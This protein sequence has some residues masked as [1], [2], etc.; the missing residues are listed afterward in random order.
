MDA[1]ALARARKAAG[2][3]DWRLA[4]RCFRAADA[5]VPLGAED[6]ELL[7]WACAWTGDLDL[8]IA[9]WERAY[10]DWLAEGRPDRAAV[11]AFWIAWW[12]VDKGHRSVAAGWY[13]R[14]ERLSAG[15]DAASRPQGYAELVRAWGARHRA[16]LDEAVERGGRAREL[17]TRAGDRDL[18]AFSMTHLAR[19]AVLAGD[20]EEGLRLADEAGAAAVGHELSPGA[21]FVVYCNVVALHFG[22]ADLKRAAEW[23][24][25][26]ARWC[27][28]QSLVGFPG[29]CRVEH[30]KVLSLTG[31]WAAAIA[32]A[33]RACAELEPFAPGLAGDAF[34]QLGELRLRT[35]DL[36]GAEAYFARAHELG[37]VP[38]P[39]RSLLLAAADVGAGLASI[40]TALQDGSWYPLERARL[41]PTFAELALA[42]GEVGAAAEAADELARIAAMYGSSALEATAATARGRVQL[43]RGE[44]ATGATLAAALRA[45]Q[46]LGLP[47]E[48]AMVRL[49]L[50]EACLVRGDRDTAR[51]ELQAALRT[52]IQ[53]GA[54]PDAGRVRQALDALD[55]PLA[56]GS[57][58][59]ARVEVR[60]LGRFG[61]TVDGRPVPDVA[62]RRASPARL[63]KL[64]ALADGRALH[65]EQVMETLWPTLAPEAAAANLHRAASQA[66]GALGARGAIVLRGGWV[67]LWPDAELDIDVER[68]E[69]HARP[70]LARGDPEDCAALAETASA[71]LLP[72]DPYLDWVQ[73]RRA[74]VHELRLALLKGAHRWKEVLTLDPLD[75]ASHRE[76]IREHAA[77]GDRAAALAQFEHLRTLLAVELGIDPAPETVA[78]RDRVVAGGSV[79][80]QERPPG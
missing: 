16:A 14:L 48:V 11:A 44:V 62:W 6:L 17:A 50:A 36:G 71:G 2:R 77:N 32:E 53:L 51:L 47:Y 79:E 27:E 45:W 54:A 66:R 23:T 49:P 21:A 22:V 18:W 10:A 60:V 35:G 80:V 15:Q 65:R 25:A 19:V 46:R 8:G 24:Q 20:R 75:E 68:F 59:P 42:A 70:A 28:R 40:R 4:L 37:T 26:L 69:R 63:V 1:D 38:Q 67:R 78:L 9:S 74:Q 39:G 13:E 33:E 64:L 31:Q 76:R 30:A 5:Q 41:L 55:A 34:Y 73:D 57:A 43:A 56:A 58:I 29:I 7:A 3:Y 12:H 61:V 52:L 72:E